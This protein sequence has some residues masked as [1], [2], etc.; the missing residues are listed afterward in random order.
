YP[1]GYQ[2]LPPDTSDIPQ[3]R[4]VYLPQSLASLRSNKPWVFDYLYETQADRSNNIINSDITDLISSGHIVAGHRIETI[5]YFDTPAYA[6]AEMRSGGN[7]YVVELGSNGSDA[8]NLIQATSTVQFRGEFPKGIYTNA[9]FGA[10]GQGSTLAEQLIDAQAFDDV[11]LA[12]AGKTL[13]IPK[14]VWWYANATA[15]GSRYYEFNSLSG[16]GFDDTEVICKGTL[17]LADWDG[18]NNRTGLGLVGVKGGEWN[19][20]FD[21]NRANQQNHEHTHLLTIAGSSDFV[22]SNIV[23]RE[24]KGDGIY[25]TDLLYNLPSPTTERFEVSKSTFVNSSDDGRNGISVIAAKDGYFGP[26]YSEGLGGALE[27]VR[28]GVTQ[29]I[30]QPGGFDIEPSFD[31]Q[32]VDRITVESVR[33]ITAGMNGVSIVGKPETQ[34]IHNVNIKKAHITMRMGTPSAAPVRYTKN[35]SLNVTIDLDATQYPEPLHTG[36]QA[37]TAGRVSENENLNYELTTY[38]VHRGP[39]IGSWPEDGLTPQDAPNKNCNIVISI[40][41]YCQYAARI[42]HVEGGKI[43]LNIGKARTSTERSGGTP[44]LRGVEFYDV[45]YGASTY[46]SGRGGSA[47]EVA[48]KGT[49]IEAN[50]LYDSEL[51]KAFFMDVGTRAISFEDVTISGDMTGWDVEPLNKF[52]V[53]PDGITKT[54]KGLASG[55]VAPVGSRNNIG[56]VVKRSP[57]PSSEIVAGN[58]VYEWIRLTTGTAGVVGTDWRERRKD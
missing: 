50:F 57:I 56:D 7:T 26:F 37:V 29:D 9:Q 1:T 3:E 35:C 27:G 34:N 46:P 48:I 33:A 45:F 47:D 6:E 58:Y 10:T 31:H 40:D 14:G 32:V 18:T 23:C 4:V 28:N 22:I 41:Y 15:V 11:L 12:S 19:F 13:L 51:N 53:K 36:W 16:V 8:G 2:P 55:S 39:E 49:V 43:T 54:A 52:D 21:G 5:S 44:L 25:I 30:Q 38:G 20:K 42:A 24:I 17:K